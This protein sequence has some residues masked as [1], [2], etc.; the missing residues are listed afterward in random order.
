[1]RVVVAT[2]CVLFWMSA[3]VFA[4]EAP[5]YAQQ[6]RPF[7]VKYCLECHNAKA[8]KGGLNLETSKA[9]G[10]GSDKGQVLI[11]G[12]P[13]ESPL[14]TVLEG[15]SKPSMPPKTAKYHPKPEEITLVRAWVKA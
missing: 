9:I 2:S 7:F 13:D 4:Q 3:S 10:E 1:M 5:S 14:V 6:V 8:L 15:K 12:K 11:A